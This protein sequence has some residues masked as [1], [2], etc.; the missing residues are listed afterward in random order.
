MDPIHRFISIQTGYPKEEWIKNADL[1]YLYEQALIFR[2]KPVNYSKKILN[3]I[4]NRIDDPKEIEELNQQIEILLK[5][6]KEENQPETD[7]YISQAI[8][9]LANDYWLLNEMKAQGAD[10]NNI[11]LL[12]ETIITDAIGVGERLFRNAMRKVQALKK[13]NLELDRSKVKPLLQ[14][15]QDGSFDLN[16]SLTISPDI[17]RIHLIINAG[18]ST[19]VRTTIPKGVIYLGGKPLIQHTIDAGKKAGF[20]KTLVVLGFKKNI[21]EAFLDKSVLTALQPTVEGTAHAVMSVFPA[22]KNFKGVLLV[23]YSDMPFIRGKTLKR[24]LEKQ[25]SENAVMTILTT[26]RKKRPEFGRLIKD[27]Q[28]NYLRIAQ[29]RIE[30]TDADQVDAGFYCFKCPEF[31]DFL[32]DVSNENNRYEYYLTDILN[33][34]SSSGQLINGHKTDNELETFGIN[35][36]NELIKAFEVAHH[37]N[38]NTLSF[39]EL[40][41]CFNN[42]PDHFKK[43]VLKFYQKFYLL[44]ASKKH[45]T[46]LNMSQ[47]EKSL[48]SQIGALFY[49]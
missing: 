42:Y 48:S 8:E 11:L 25:E 13:A 49:Y 18:R 41:E 36:P 12:K 43:E 7:L 35:R 23:S 32:G 34:I 47:I 30:E 46:K 14:W 26:S 39:S 29:V 17:K 6:A 9:I 37:L 21:N 45:F 33:K 16:Q 22:L 4:A 20:E 24:L 5:Q 1:K 28:G 2:Q 27:E 40:T 31:W 3:I 15:V 10:Q 38:D 19:R 44:T